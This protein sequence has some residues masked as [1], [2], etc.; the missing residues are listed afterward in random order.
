MAGFFFCLKEGN[1]LTIYSGRHGMN[2]KPLLLLIFFT[3]MAI[4]AGTTGLH[5]APIYKTVDEHGNVTFT[6]SP[7]ADQESEKVELR[8]INTQQATLPPPKPEITSS[9]QTQDPKSEEVPYTVS[10]LVEPLEGSTVPTGQRDVPVRLNLVPPLQE[11][12]SVVFYHNESAENPPGTSTHITLRNLIRGEH[13]IYAEIW[14][15]NSKIKAKSQKVTF[16]VQ[17]YHPKMGKK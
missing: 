4:T 11:G 7:P 1:L 16:Y 17:R 3:A 9:K 2:A 14:D 15:A 5:A 12:H 10:R 6:D 13:T 8:P